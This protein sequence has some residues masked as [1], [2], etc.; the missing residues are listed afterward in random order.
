MKRM[1]TILA[2]LL[3]TAGLHAQGVPGGSDDCQ[4]DM[5]PPTFGAGSASLEDSA[6][7]DLSPLSVIWLDSSGCDCTVDMRIVGSYRSCNSVYPAIGAPGACENYSYDLQIVA[8][9]STQG[10]FMGVTA[11][12]T[13]T[14]Q[15]PPIFFVDVA[16]VPCD[17]T[18]VFSMGTSCS[19]FYEV[20][21]RSIYVAPPAPGS[22]GPEL[23]SSSN[24]AA[25]VRAVVQVTTT[26]TAVSC[27]SGEL[28]SQFSAYC[29]QD[30]DTNDPADPIPIEGS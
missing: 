26:S 16:T 11:S 6:C 19:C 21:D 1:A 17:D 3:V 30:C 13:T 18:F 28:N 10:N 20:V 23:A 27:T 29:V 22:S 4:W 2:M 7:V 24:T 5:G 9:S 25:P 14:G 15:P 12:G 8:A